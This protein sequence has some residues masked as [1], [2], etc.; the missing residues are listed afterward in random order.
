MDSFRYNHQE[1]L[2]SLGLR[3]PDKKKGV[4]YNSETQPVQNDTQRFNSEPDMKSEVKFNQH[5]SL[6]RQEDTSRDRHQSEKKALL[7]VL[8]IDLPDGEQSNVQVF[9]R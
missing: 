5:G 4:Y 3:S 7:F 9:K 6:S 1:L 8:T 2:Q